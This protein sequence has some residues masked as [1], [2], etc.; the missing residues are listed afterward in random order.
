[1]ERWQ[2]IL[3]ESITSLD[4]LARFLP[5]EIEPL[6]P[7]I[8]RYPLRLTR[9]YLSLIREKE[10]P[11]WGQ[12]VPDPRELEQ[13]DLSIDPLNENGFAPVSGLIHRYPNRVVLLASSSCPTLCRFCTRKN[14]MGGEGGLINP[15][16]LEPALEYIE[17]RP[18]IREV[19]LSGGDPLL[20]ADDE[21]E[22]ILIRLRQIVHVEVIRIHTRTPVTLPDRITLRLCRM[23]KRYHPLYLNTQFNHPTEITPLSANACT[24]L[25][26]AGI[27]LGNQTVL[28]RGVNDDPEVMKQLMQ[29]LLTIRVR[30]YYLHQMDLVKGTGHFRT[31]IQKGLHIVAELRGHASGMATPSYVIALPGGK[32]KVALLP[33]DVKKEGKTFF[34]RNYLGEVVEYPYGEE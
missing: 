29:K 20:L 8:D 32:G 25:A 11:I 18:T 1:M 16:S 10:D 23:L 17:R 24:R 27:P 26:D 28:L 9:T 7:V 3:S 6:K 5:I 34:L 19:I 14:R 13:E 31:S 33:D 30:P 12:C 15:N 21:L 2:K 4:E 22:T